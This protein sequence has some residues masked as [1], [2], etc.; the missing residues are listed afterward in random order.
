MDTTMETNVATGAVP[1]EN[2]AAQGQETT[3]AEVLQQIDTA[4]GTAADKK[5][6][7]KEPEAE[8]AAEPEKKEK[9][10]EK[11]ISETE[12][13]SRLQKEREKWEAE[14]AEEARIAAMSPEEK[15]AAEQQNKDAKIQ[16]LEAELQ[17][18]KLERS[19]IKELEAAGLSAD[20]A[21]V[22]DYSGEENMKKSLEAVKKAVTASAEKLVNARLKGK[23]PEGLGS[24]T[25]E[26][27][28]QAELIR[29]GINGE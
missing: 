14:K 19:A 27:E 10:A 23:T 7:E 17:K 20:L 18:G 15:A 12:L 16:Q 5:E 2:A 3:A 21:D 6:P 4:L 11:V 25:S 13:E 9:P 22:L 26:A 1:A 24:K 29:K 28:A 8:K